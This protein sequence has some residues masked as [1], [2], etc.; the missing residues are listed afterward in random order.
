MGRQAGVPLLLAGI[1]RFSTPVAQEHWG[2][3][4]W[5]SAADHDPTCTGEQTVAFKAH[6]RRV[7]PALLFPSATQQKS[8]HRGALLGDGRQLEPS[9]H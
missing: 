4:T 5:R 9:N 8:A 1:P 2:P 7:R 6:Q 3:A